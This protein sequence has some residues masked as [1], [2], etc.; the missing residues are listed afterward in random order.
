MPGP[1]QQGDEL[2][3]QNTD[4]PLLISSALSTDWA[5]NDFMTVEHT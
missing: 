5:Y 4:Y 3:I 2:F 1:P